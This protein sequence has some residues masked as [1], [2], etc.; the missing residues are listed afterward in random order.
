MWL[1]RAIFYLKLN[2]Y[3]FS[4]CYCEHG[5]NVGIIFLMS[6]VIWVFRP[7]HEAGKRNCLKC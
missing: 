3:P 5:Q 4:C 2:I 6:L 1:W 7:Y